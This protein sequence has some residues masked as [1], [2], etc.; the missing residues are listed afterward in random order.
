[1]KKILINGAIIIGLYLLFVIYL[2]FYSERIE[3]LNESYKDNSLIS[4]N[5]G[6]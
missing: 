1:M 3:Q 2:L 6:E 4:I 5:Y